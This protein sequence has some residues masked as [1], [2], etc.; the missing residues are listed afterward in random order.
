MNQ[1]LTAYT[2]KLF[3]ASVRFEDTKKNKEKLIHTLRETKEFLES[4]E[5]AQVF[6]QSVARATQEQV[7]FHIED[8]VN[9]ALKSLF[10]GYTFE[11]KFQDARGKTEALI[12]LKDV[13]GNEYD[14]LEDN[15]GGVSAV[16][17]FA[18]R[19]SLLILSKNRRTLI[20]DQPFS[21]ISSD[22]LKETMYEVLRELVD[23]LEVQCIIVSHDPMLNDI[24][25]REFRVTKVK[26]K[27]VVKVI[28]E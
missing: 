16:I 28:G 26:D 22:G 4:I 2:N 25:D 27:S 6:F 24:A 11:L 1:R 13:S 12:L 20:L 19:M 17:S 8:I 15:G 21:D 7:R 3:T 5:E 18:L 10:P 14:P 9:M 23:E